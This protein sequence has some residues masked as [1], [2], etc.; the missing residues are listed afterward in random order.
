MTQAKR[1]SGIDLDLGDRCSAVAYGWAKKTFDVRKGKLGAPLLEVDGSFS[2]L[3]DFGNVKVAMCSDGI[4]TKAEVAER[5]GRYDTLGFDLVAMVVDDLAANGIEPVNLSNVL[6]V[7][8]LDPDVVDQLMAGLYRAA[9]LA[10]A[11]VTGGEIAELGSRIRGWGEGMHF[12][13]CATAIGMLRG[14]AKPIDGSTVEPG[15]SVITLRSR[16]FRSNGFSLARRILRADS[17]E[18]WHEQPWNESLTW[19]DVLL[20]PSRIYSPAIQGL[21]TLGCEIHG[22]AHVTG[23]GVPGNLDRVLGPKKLGARLDE[24]FA[25]HDFMADLARRGRVEPRDAY[26]MWNMGN[27]MLLVVSRDDAA[28]CLEVLTEQDYEARVAGEVTPSPGIS[29]RDR[30]HDNET[31]EFQQES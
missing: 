13:W 3:M 20:L 18:L 16:G 23:G 9:R 11:A 14:A 4:G 2:N 25:P 22:I 7:D 31:L 6:D 30:L 28:R 8:F 21:L 24:L 10:G 17:G 19:G 29:L 26:R 12:N 5:V 15:D 27:G 1:Q